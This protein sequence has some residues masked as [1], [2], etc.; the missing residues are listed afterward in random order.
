FGA[1]LGGPLQKDKTFLFGNFEGLYQHL[2][3]TGVDLVPDLNARNGYLPC[4]LVTPAPNCPAS[5]LDFVG[6]SPLA[7]AWPTPTAGAPDFGGISEAF[8]HP[9]QTIRDDF[10]TA[11]LDHIFSQKDTL[12]AVYTIDDSADYTPTSTNLYS[13]DVT[14][15]REQVLSFE[16]THVFSPTVLNTARIGFSRAGYFFTGEPTPGTPAASLPGFLAGRPIGAIVVG[17]S[18]AS[19]PTAQLSLA[20]SNNGSNLALARNLFTYEDRVSVT[21]GRHLITAGAWF[22]RLRSNEMLALSQYG[23]ATFTSLQ[24][25][26]QG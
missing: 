11:R 15:L 9:L 25:L 10:G 4:K 26:L 2:H 7:A 16:E 20:G 22:Q 5:G 13:T 1:S 14:S 17:G 6:I 24:T 8:N 12:N 19:N 3:Q 18:A 23:Q 21:K